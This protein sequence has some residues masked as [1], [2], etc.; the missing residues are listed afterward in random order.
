V[1]DDGALIVEQADRRRI[2]V[3]PQHLA[4]LEPAS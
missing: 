1:L 2:A 3:R 4:R